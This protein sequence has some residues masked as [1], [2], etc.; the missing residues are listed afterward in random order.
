MRDDDTDAEGAAA[1]DAAV[2]ALAARFSSL[3]VQTICGVLLS[4]RCD[5]PVRLRLPRCCVPP[6][7]LRACVCDAALRAH[8]GG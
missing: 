8:A 4:H 7:L 2:A 6:G 5:V 3:S 1:T